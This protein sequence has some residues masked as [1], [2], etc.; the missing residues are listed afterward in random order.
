[1][2]FIKSYWKFDS[3]QT[4]LSKNVKQRRKAWGSFTVNGK[5][6]II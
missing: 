1:M 5:Y 2:S 4:E 6:C 3:I